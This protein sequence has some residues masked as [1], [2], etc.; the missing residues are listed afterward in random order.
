MYE[1]HAMTYDLRYFSEDTLEFPVFNFQCQRPT[2]WIPLNFTLFEPIDVV[3]ERYK[4]EKIS[5]EAVSEMNCNGTVET[6]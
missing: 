4:S 3:P 6:K 5:Y 1:V 2:A